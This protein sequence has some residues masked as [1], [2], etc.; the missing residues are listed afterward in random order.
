MHILLVVFVDLEV[1]RKKANQVTLAM[2]FVVLVVL[3]QGTGTLE[4]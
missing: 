1:I 3:V 4:N 2:P